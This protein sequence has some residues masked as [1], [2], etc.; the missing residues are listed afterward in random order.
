MSDI[1]T[2]EDKSD[3]EIAAS[4]TLK[5]FAVFGPLA[6]NAVACF[7]IAIYQGMMMAGL[8]AHAANGFPPEI[9]VMGAFAIAGLFAIGGLVLCWP[10]G[11]LPAL[12]IGLVTSLYGQRHGTVPFWVPCGVAALPGLLALAVVK[13]SIIG[14]L[15][16]V[17]ILVVPAFVSWCFA[18]KH[19][20]AV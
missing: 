15:C 20:Q 14:P 7:G 18:R 2:A 16:L 10:I 5:T 12:G 8:T 17:G 6:G 13:D 19:W 4:K 3:A 1:G 11:I 9:A